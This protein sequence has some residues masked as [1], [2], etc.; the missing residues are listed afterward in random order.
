MI[1]GGGK[2]RATSQREWH[3]SRPCGRK[4]KGPEGGFLACG[5]QK[6]VSESD[7]LKFKE[8]KKCV[9]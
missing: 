7:D 8:H 6:N 9:S 3:V 1:M 2:G 4:H 5:R